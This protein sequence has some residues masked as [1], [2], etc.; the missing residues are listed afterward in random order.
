MDVDAGGKGLD[1]DGRIAREGSLD[2]V[3]PPFAPLV[4]DVRRRVAEAY[5]ARLHSAYLYGSI[6][7]GTARPGRSDLDLLIALHAR[8]T[9][10]D[11]ETARALESALDASHEVIDGGGILL[12]GTETLLS[13]AERYDMGWFVACLCTP[14]IGEDLAA[15][16]PRYRPD[17][18]LARETNGSLDLR[19]P[20]WRRQN[21]AA[22]GD[23]AERARLSRAYARHL[24]RTA[25]TLVMPRWGGWTSDLT[26]SAEIFAHYYPDHP[27]RGDQ[28]RA[29]AAVALE[30]VTDPAV[31]AEYADDLGPWLA[32]EYARVHGHRTPRP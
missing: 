21:A 2:R 16:L 14:L 8:P 11:E 5:G 32:A 25:F 10:A 1:A 27:E 6:P 28:M 30:P 20:R 15:R 22:A 23:P 26:R 17:S 3:Q 18:R 29:A 24:V 9:K 12:H 13:D 7:R 4:D 31:L 19:L